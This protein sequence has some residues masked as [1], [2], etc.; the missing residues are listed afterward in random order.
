MARACWHP[1]NRRQ[2]IGAWRHRPSL[3]AYNGGVVGDRREIQWAMDTWI[4][5]I[6]KAGRCHPLLYVC[7]VCVLETVRTNALLDLPRMPVT[8]MNKPY[9]FCTSSLVLST[10]GGRQLP[11]D[12]L[13]GQIFGCAW[14][15]LEAWGGILLPKMGT[16]P[17]EDIDAVTAAAE[18]PYAHSAAVRQLAH[19]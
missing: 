12:A 3:P 2:G 9:T 13:S 18:L 16:I 10:G 15:D 5:Q 6:D 8:T 4:F 17:C 19:R 7:R 11:A 1:W 14:R